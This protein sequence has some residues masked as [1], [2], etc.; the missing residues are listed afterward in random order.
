MR[1][2]VQGELPHVWK[3]AAGFAKDGRNTILSGVLGYAWQKLP[4][5]FVRATSLLLVLA[6]W[7]LSKL[8][9]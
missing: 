8:S 1:L 4:E 7:R 9:L 5:P 6:S 3:I 2:C